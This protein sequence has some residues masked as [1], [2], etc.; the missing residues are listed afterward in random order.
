MKHLFKL[1]FILCM[2]FALTQGVKA[3]IGKFSSA[4]EI[5]A[6]YIGDDGGAFY[7]HA[8]GKKIRGVGEHPGKNYSLLLWGEKKGNIITLK[9]WSTPKEIQKSEG[10]LELKLTNKN[11]L[12]VISETGGFPASILNPKPLSKS[13][14]LQLPYKKNP[15]WE[16][17]K[18]GNIS[19]AFK[20]TSKN[21]ICYTR[22]VGK[23][24]RMYC[25]SKAG[26]DK[27]PSYAYLFLG[28]K[29]AAGKVEGKVYAMSKGKQKGTKKA[30]FY[31]K[32]ENSMT[33]SSGFKLGGKN[34]K[35]VNVDYRKKVNAYLTTLENN[36]DNMLKLV[37]K[38]TTTPKAV[39]GPSQQNSHQE[40]GLKKCAVQSWEYSKNIVEQTVLK[41][42]DLFPGAIVKINANYVKGE[43]S[44][45][46]ELAQSKRSFS[47]TRLA[48]FSKGKE[49]FTIDGLNMSKYQ[50]QLNNRLD[51]WRKNS[52]VSFSP[53]KGDESSAFTWSRKQ[54]LMDIGVNYTSPSVNVFTDV[55]Y[56][57]TS[58]SYVFNAYARYDYFS[59]L[60]D[61]PKSPA[62]WFKDGTTLRQVKAVHKNK[63]MRLGY[64]SK[65]TYGAVMLVSF[66][67]DSNQSFADVSTVVNAITGNGKLD[68]ELDTKFS[69]VVQGVEIRYMTSGG[70]TKTLDHSGSIQDIIKQYNNIKRNLTDN[71]DPGQGVPV[72]YQVKYLKNNEVAKLGQSADYE[73]KKCELTPDFVSFEN[74]GGYQVAFRFEDASGEVIA[75]K[76]MRKGRKSIT[77]TPD[78]KLPITANITTRLWGKPLKSK[79]KW[80]H[81]K[82]FIV[83]PGCHYRMGGISQKKAD[84]KIQE[85]D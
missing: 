40:G 64:V 77:F 19:G 23:M 62:D 75:E 51:Y 59:V 61:A 55:S 30:T 7:M 63:H 8:D 21:V 44:L 67:F 42:I 66:E 53:N 72:S 84:L 34:W 25:E 13:I 11:I 24:V 2:C 41:E 80:N 47:I 46:S 56:E 52:R 6:F 15:A 16:S 81:F 37:R 65:I 83:T 10:T 57:K 29:G 76:I 22:Q 1:L 27:K 3:Q 36:P 45:I 39:G 26:G 5:Q 73:K 9:W 33:A 43:P 74:A 14:Q 32:D 20:S 82:R 4:A 54:F 50:T 71:S 48:G 70:K 79:G 68:I 49:S 69:K 28:T 31:I 60:V 38:P 18:A 58:E 12:Q 35:R 17:D 78:T 85:C